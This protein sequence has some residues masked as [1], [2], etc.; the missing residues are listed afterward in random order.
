FRNSNVPAPPTSTTPE[1]RAEPALI[2]SKRS[3]PVDSAKAPDAMLSVRFGV[4]VLL[5][6]RS[7]PVETVTTPDI[8]SASAVRKFSRPEPVLVKPTLPLTTAVTS[9]VLEPTFQ[10]EAAKSMVVGWLN[11]PAPVIEFVKVSA[12]GE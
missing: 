12:L 4:K 11:A 6:K 9:T 2:E 10:V 1:P 5:A 3:V 8:A 7:V